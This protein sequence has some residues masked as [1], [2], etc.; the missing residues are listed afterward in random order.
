[1]KNNFLLKLFWALIDLVTL[2][3]ALATLAGFLGKAW[4][5]FDLISHFRVQYLVGFS[6]LLSINAIRGR[7]QATIA[8]AV[9]FAVNA[10]LVVPLWF[11]GL[12][13]EPDD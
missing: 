4:W 5:I 11:G 2:G 9:F 1:M 8:V 3:L 6:I 7:K 13:V 12:K 10:I